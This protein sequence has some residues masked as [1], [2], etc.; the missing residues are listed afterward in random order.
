VSGPDLSSEVFV[1]TSGLYAAL[2]AADQ[3]HAVAAPLLDTLLSGGASLVTSSYVVLETTGLLQRRIGNT[4]ARGFL[5]EFLPSLDVAW[6]ESELHDRGVEAWPAA[7]RGDL[8]LVDCVSF[9]LMHE[10]RLDLAFAFDRHF[11]EF[12]FR[13]L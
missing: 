1:D 2:N 5:L 11:E 7:G 13:L 8:S 6:V 9:A 10:L 4:A 3:D 12:G